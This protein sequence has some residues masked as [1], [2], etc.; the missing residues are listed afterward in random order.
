MLKSEGYA[1]TAL[2]D[3]S[4]ALAAAIAEKPS[5]VITDVRMPG[6]DGYHFAQQL[7]EALGTDCP[8]III[9]TSRDTTAPSEKSAAALSGADAVLQK[10][11]K[12][13][14]LLKTVRRLLS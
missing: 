11:F 5:L 2:S 8:K 14:E 13:E 7:G 9:M 3:G 1:V 10:P 6:L 12:T 4:R